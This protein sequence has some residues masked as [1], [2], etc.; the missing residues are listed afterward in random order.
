MEE[1]EKKKEDIYLKQKKF[2]SNFSKLFG[3]SNKPSRDDLMRSLSGKKISPFIDFMIHLSSIE[4]KEKE[5]LK[6][7]ME[8]P[9]Q[10]MKSDDFAGKNEHNRVSKAELDYISNEMKVYFANSSSRNFKQK[11]NLSIIDE[12]DDK[13]I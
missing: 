5:F 11:A 7:F 4:F 6:T 9:V 12:E 13:F 2:Q 8:N 10:K 3:R 1:S